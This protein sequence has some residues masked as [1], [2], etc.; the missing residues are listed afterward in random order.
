MKRIMNA[1]AV[2]T[3]LL[4]TV[5]LGMDVKRAQAE[6]LY[7]GSFNNDTVLRF[8]GKTGRF[9]DTFVTKR[10]GKLDGPVGLTFS[11]KG[12]NL[13]LIS[14]FTASVLRYN[15]ITGRFLNTFI[16]QEKGDLRF[17]Q[18]LTFGTD[19]KLYVSSTGT[20]T[21][22][23][24]SRRGDFI[25]PLF[26]VDTTLC[27]APFG[28]RFGP[29]QNLYFSCT[30]SN[31]IRRYNPKTR[32]TKTVGTAST[33]NAA[34]GGLTFGPDGNLYVANFFANT[35][36]RYNPKTA[37]LKVFIK[38]VDSPVQ[39][40]FGSDGNLYVSSNAS[41]KVRQPLPGKVLRFNG[42]T[43][44]FIDEF[45]PE[46]TGGLDGAGWLV[47]KN[48][49]CFKVRQKV[50]CIPDYGYKRKVSPINKH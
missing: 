31:T 30:F 21:I 41:N 27:D 42:K 26:P 3:V 44:A 39:P 16:P 25:G 32:R 47:F 9:I 12:K 45:I 28:V 22:N 8:D 40:V 20:D 37:Q 50:I 46:K 33:P 11:P 35:I 49:T 4:A 2:S 17:P 19:G 34:P 1:L 36:D 10:S 6:T 13:Y 48:E 43:G 23:V 15:G 18:D 5:G 7:V 38:E 24:Y 14:F 29:D